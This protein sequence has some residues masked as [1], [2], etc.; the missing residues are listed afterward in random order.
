[1]R[2]TTAKYS[3]KSVEMILRIRFFSSSSWLSRSAGGQTRVRPGQ[4]AGAQ[5]RPPLTFI[6]AVQNGFQHFVAVAI[7]VFLPD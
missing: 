7:A 4:G 2:E 3:G 5:R 6:H 1:M